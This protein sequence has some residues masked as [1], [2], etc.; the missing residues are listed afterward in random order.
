MLI[1]IAT[2]ICGKIK[3]KVMKFEHSY[4]KRKFLLRFEG[5]VCYPNESYYACRVKVS[6]QNLDIWFMLVHASVV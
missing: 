1:S 5:Y 4:Q 6:P 2:Y 3:V